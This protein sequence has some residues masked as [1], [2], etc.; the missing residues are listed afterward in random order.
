MWGGAPACWRCPSL[1]L[2]AATVV[3][4]GAAGCLEDLPQPLQCP[5]PAQVEA[6]GCGF[7][8]PPPDG[9]FTPDQLSC[10]T[11]PRAQCACGGDECSTPSPACF[12]GEDC[13]PAVTAVAGDR[14]RCGRLGP[15]AIGGP[16]PAEQLCACG[17]ARC[18]A[19]C[20]GI[21]PVFGATTN[22]VADVSDFFV[23][24]LRIAELLPAAGRVG[25]Y[26]RVRGLAN[27][28][29]LL[30]RGDPSNL[31]TLEAVNGGYLLNNPLNESF[32]EQ[33]LFD[34]PFVGIDAYRW[35]DEASKP[36]VVSI[37]TGTTR[38]VEL[39]EIDCVVPFWVPP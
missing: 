29:V 39:F 3:A 32:T 31:E 30:L 21:G 19:V 22:A 1:G 16:L 5:P 11:G 10:L 17:C 24:F 26:L 20:D 8:E 13:P 7:I 36:T 33:V 12:P 35:N 27:V 14:V 28:V 9:C 18:M 2:G 34:Q 4:L 15:A 23:P 38:T 37:M 25:V 6:S